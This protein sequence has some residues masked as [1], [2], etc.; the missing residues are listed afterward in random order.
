MTIAEDERPE[1]GRLSRFSAWFSR[2]FGWWASWRGLAILWVITLSGML[3]SEWSTHYRMWTLQRNEALPRWFMAVDSTLPWLSLIMMDLGIV[4]GFIVIYT[5]RYRRAMVG[6]RASSSR[7]VLESLLFLAGFLAY[8]CSGVWPVIWL[9][10][11][12]FPGFHVP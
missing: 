2:H 5:F 9:M 3:M 1:R 11:R 12:L 4:G 8:V 7:Y 10:G 6:H